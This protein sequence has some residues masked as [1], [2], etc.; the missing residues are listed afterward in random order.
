M[1]SE[2]GPSYHDLRGVSDPIQQP[3]MNIVFRS[4]L[5]IFYLRGDPDIY[6]GGVSLSLPSNPNEPHDVLDSHTDDDETISDLPPLLVD[7]ETTD[8]DSLLSLIHI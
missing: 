8:T 4:Y 7:G 2:E 1:T 3:P 6:G 5:Q